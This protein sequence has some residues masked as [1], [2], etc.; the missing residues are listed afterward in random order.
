MQCFQNNSFRL[1]QYLWC[2]ICWQHPDHQHH[3]HRHHRCQCNLERK[4]KMFAHFLVWSHATKNGKM[5]QNEINY[6]TICNFPRKNLENTRHCEIRYG[7]KVLMGIMFGLQWMNEWII[8]FL[9]PNNLIYSPKEVIE[10]WI[11]NSGHKVIRERLFFDIVKK[12][13]W[14]LPKKIIMKF[15]VKYVWKKTEPIFRE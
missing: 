12:I 15:W 2:S 9:F 4:K 6:K 8:I 11:H 7:K 13:C 10:L 5:A 14:R 1:Q 3:H